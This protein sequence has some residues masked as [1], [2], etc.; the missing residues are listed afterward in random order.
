[1][2]STRCRVYTGTCGMSTKGEKVANR[3]N[4]HPRF[5]PTKAWWRTNHR[6]RGLGLPLITKRLSHWTRYRVTLDIG[7]SEEYRSLSDER[8]GKR[9]S[10][11]IDNRRVDDPSIVTGPAWRDERKADN[12][13]I[14]FCLR[15]PNICGHQ[16]RDTHH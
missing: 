3:R 7:S 14:R 2:S 4:V 12:F 13:Y 15:R 16:A 11:F 8:N 5:P 6:R 9:H 1:M 10:L